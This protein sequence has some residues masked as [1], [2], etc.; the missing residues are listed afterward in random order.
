MAMHGQLDDACQ[1]ILGNHLIMQSCTEES[2]HKQMICQ[3]S[4]FSSISKLLGPERQGDLLA[5]ISYRD[6]RG[7]PE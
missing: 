1:E 5:K 6:F 7:F 4:C 3:L 2:H